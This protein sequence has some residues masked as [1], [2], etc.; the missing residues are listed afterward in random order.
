L[1]D[2]REI[3]DILKGKLKTKELAETEKNFSSTEQPKN[4]LQE[5]SLKDAETPPNKP[6]KKS[7]EVKKP[8]PTNNKESS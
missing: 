8:K 5:F 1:D 6:T 7:K 2:H 3:I 4:K